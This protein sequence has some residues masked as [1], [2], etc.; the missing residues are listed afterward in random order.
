MPIRSRDRG[1]EDLEA[2]GHDF[3]ADAIAVRDGDGCLGGHRRNKQDIKPTGGATREAWEIGGA[4]LQ[5]VRVF[6]RSLRKMNQPH[7]TR[8]YHLLARFPDVYR[9]SFT[10]FEI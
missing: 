5:P 10:I 8:L 7:R 6:F 2:G 9:K 4:G 1:L 3:G